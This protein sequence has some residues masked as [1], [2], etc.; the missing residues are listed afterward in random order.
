MRSSS[1]RFHRRSTAGVVERRERRRRARAVRLGVALALEVVGR[2]AA[3]RA[4]ESSAM[5]ADASER[6]A[7]RARRAP[8][9]ST[10]CSARARRRASGWASIAPL[11]ERARGAR[12]RRSARLR[13]RGRGVVGARRHRRSS[14]GSVAYPALMPRV[15]VAAAQLNLVV[16]DL[17][18]NVGAHPRRLRAGRR[19]RLRPRGVPGARDHRLPARRPAAAPGVRRA[20]AESLDKLAARTGRTAAVVGFPEA[21]RDL[22]NAAAVCADGQR[23][24]RLPQAPAPELRGVRR[25]A[26]LRAVDRRRPAVRRRRRAG[27]ASRSARTRGARTARSSRRPPAAP[28]SSSTSTRRRT[29]RA[30][31]HERETMLATRAADASVPDRST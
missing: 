9:R 25:A 14:H 24:G 29:T 1:R 17:D 27:R 7:T 19:R 16:G 15:R 30:G 12:R 13:H 18:G 28:S 21:E 3:D 31:S 11:H 8:S 22:A 2:R 6:D 26:L 23:P 20:G 4:V 5:T 10:G